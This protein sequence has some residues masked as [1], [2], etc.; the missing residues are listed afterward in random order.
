MLDVNT[1]L[2]QLNNNDNITLHFT[3]CS[4]T[5]EYHWKFDC[6][7]IKLNYLKSKIKHNVWSV[8]IKSKIVLIYFSVRKK[9]LLIICSSFNFNWKF[10]KMAPTLHRRN[11]LDNISNRLL[12]PSRNT[13]RIQ[14]PRRQ[15]GTTWNVDTQRQNAVRRLHFKVAPTRGNREYKL[16]TGIFSFHQ[17]ITHLRW[18]VKKF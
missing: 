7:N 16:Y 15:L 11:P 2:V 5:N 18:C 12:I 6:F 13:R 17:Y 1:L 9:K 8:K 10:A 4:S 14:R 3:L